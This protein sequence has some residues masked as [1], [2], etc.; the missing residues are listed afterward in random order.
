MLASAT[1]SHSTPLHRIGR[2]RRPG[3]LHAFTLVFGSFIL[4]LTSPV[5]Q[6]DVWGY[7]DANGVGH[8]ANHPVDK[9]YVL[10]FKEKST[11]QDA[12]IMKRTVLPAGKTVDVALNFS[13]LEAQRTLPG[14][15]LGTTLDA[16]AVFNKAPQ[17]KPM[18]KAVQ[19]AA[20]THQVDAELVQAIIATE[21]GFDH[22]AV[23]NRGAVGLMQIL[24]TTAADMGVQV[25]P[26]K[27]INTQLTDPKT[28]I[29]AGTRYISYLLKKFPGQM[30]LAIAAYNAGE[31]NVRNAGNQVPNFKETQNYVRAV[32]GL[33]AS[34]KPGAN[35]P[36]LALLGQAAPR[37]DGK[38][39]ATARLRQA[40]LVQVG[41][42]APVA[43][44]RPQQAAMLQ[45]P[46]L[47][48]AP[49]LPQPAPARAPALSGP[50]VSAPNLEPAHISPATLA[51]ASL[52]PTVEKTADH[53]AAN[54]VLP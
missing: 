12:R 40:G 48:S 21:S 15:K 3:L 47:R 6:A 34:L 23:S 10:F 9:R 16:V 46:V 54:L 51:D 25:E 33:Y 13:S 27:D 32:L 4:L 20:K 43:G 39:A 41:Y 49:L 30:E 44:G 11:A 17:F 36:D 14:V 22:T 18:R 24:P 50:M 8:Y 2:V 42:S 29:M 53:T 26:G 52:A 38:S 5:T 31:G 45:R 1:G 19:V 28:N 37:G 7:V 35:I